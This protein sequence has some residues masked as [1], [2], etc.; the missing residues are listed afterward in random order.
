M[1]SAPTHV[2]VALGSRGG[3]D[4]RETGG[5]T[6]HGEERAVV[7]PPPLLHQLRHV[8]R[9]ICLRHRVLDVVQRPR[10]PLPRH[11]GKAQDA[12]FRQIPVQIPA[13]REPH[14]LTRRA[15]RGAIATNMFPLNG[16]SG[17][18]PGLRSIPLK[19]L[20]RGHPTPTRTRFRLA[21]REARGAGVR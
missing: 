13:Q 5:R 17:F 21:R 12:I 10:F 11:D 14:A 9:H 2:N 15:Q 18:P 4:E 16:E 19:Y 7:P 20:P 6:K 3:H 1:E 8:G